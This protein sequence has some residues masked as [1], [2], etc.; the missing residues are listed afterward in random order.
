MSQLE[1]MLGSVTRRHD[2]I[3]IHES[4]VLQLVSQCLLTTLL[5]V[6]SGWQALLSPSVASR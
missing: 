3:S 2:M 4:E 6:T 5:P 1:Y